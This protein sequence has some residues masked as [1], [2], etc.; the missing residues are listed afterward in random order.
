MSS[1]RD[2]RSMVR[3]AAGR[4]KCCAVV[5]RVAKSGSVGRVYTT[6]FPSRSKMLEEADTCGF[7]VIRYDLLAGDDQSNHD[8]L[9]QDYGMGPMEEFM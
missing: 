6:V 1:R 9:V 2:T 8:L 3:F 7:A 5:A 4:A